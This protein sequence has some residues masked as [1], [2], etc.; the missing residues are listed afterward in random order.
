MTDQANA[1]AGETGSPAEILAFEPPVV[2]VF[3]PAFRGMAPTP[4]LMAALNELYSELLLCRAVIVNGEVI[5]ATEL[6][7]AG[8]TAD[9]VA[10]GCLVVGT[11]VERIRITLADRL[12][13]AG[14]PGPEPGPHLLN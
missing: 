11:W 14:G 9:D 2:R 8:M 12:G 5:V 1:A 13:P 6:R 7:G 10:W 3:A 4:E